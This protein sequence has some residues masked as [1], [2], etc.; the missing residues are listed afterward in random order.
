[1][2]FLRIAASKNE[3]SEQGCEVYV[4][5]RKTY[6]LNQQR[7]DFSTWIRGWYR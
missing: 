3:F 2:D 1:M 6:P 5:S 4:S 7:L